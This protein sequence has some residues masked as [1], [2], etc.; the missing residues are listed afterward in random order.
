MSGSKVRVYSKRRYGRHAPSDVAV[1]PVDRSS[2]FGNPFI[3]EEESQRDAAISAHVEWLFGRERKDLSVIAEKYGLPYQ[4]VVCG[5]SRDDIMERLEL[6]A[7]NLAADGADLGLVCWCAP[8]RCHGDILAR[9]LNRRVKE[10]SDG[11]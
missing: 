7:R 6:V 8:K 10:L 5:L 11:E 4:A 3:M 1:L 2:V 9:W